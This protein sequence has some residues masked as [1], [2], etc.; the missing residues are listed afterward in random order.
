[1]QQEGAYATLIGK[2]RNVKTMQVNVTHYVIEVAMGHIT[3]NVHRVSTTRR[4]TNMDSASVMII[5]QVPHVIY[6]MVHVTKTA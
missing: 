2:D 4:S 1:M 5:G 6:I 3:P